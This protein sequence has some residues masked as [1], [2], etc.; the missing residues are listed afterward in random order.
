SQPSFAQ[1]APTGSH[2]G[3]RASDTGHQ[4]PSDRGGYATSIPLDFPPAHGGLPVPVQIVSGGKGFGAA[5]VG[6]DVPLSYV[7]VD[8]SFANRRPALLP[9]GTPTARK[10][11]SV[12]LPGRH[13]EMLPRGTGWVARNGNDLVMQYE[14]GGYKVY[15]GNG[16]TYTFIQNPA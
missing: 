1:L 5:G 13:E 10:R 8:N 6:W 9:N 14:N 2:Y 3:G 12:S 11:I 16:L 7:Y 4:G 15:D